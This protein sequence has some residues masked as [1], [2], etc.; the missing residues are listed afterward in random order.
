MI[1]HKILRRVL[2]VPEPRFTAI[3][4]VS[5]A[6]EACNKEELPWRE[7]IHIKEELK[8]YVIRTDVENRGGNVLINVDNQTGDTTTAFVNR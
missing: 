8:R 4:A 7:P 5:F 2:N 1:L 6:K 3:E